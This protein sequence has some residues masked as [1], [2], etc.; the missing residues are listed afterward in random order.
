KLMATG[1]LT[2]EEYLELEREQALLLQIQ[3]GSL[4]DALD[5][6]QKQRDELIKR[7]DLNDQ[8]LAKLE[9][10]NTRLAEMLLAQVDINWENG[11]GLKQLDEK[12]AKLKKERDELVKNT[13]S[14]V[15]KTQEYRDQLKQIGRAHV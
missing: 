9:L 2:Q 11:K 14:E 6:L 15:K 1:A 8:E 13:S 4:A 7:R 12:I 5:T 3:N 10:I